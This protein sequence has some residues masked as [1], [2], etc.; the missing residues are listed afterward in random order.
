[1]AHKRPDHVTWN[2]ALLAASPASTLSPYPKNCLHEV[3]LAQAFIKPSVT[4]L[5]PE[6]DDLL[7]TPKVHLVSNQL[8]TQDNT[9]P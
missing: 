4:K 3:V 9:R 5:L 7:S 1:M 2:V 6:N 8:I